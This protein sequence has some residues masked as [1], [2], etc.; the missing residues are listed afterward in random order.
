MADVSRHLTRMKRDITTILNLRKETFHGYG[1]QYYLDVDPRFGSRDDLV[2]LVNT[3]HHHGIRV[4]LDIILNHS[5]DVFAYRPQEFRCDVFDE[6]GHF[7]GKE[8]CW[9]NDGTIY[10]VEGFRVD[11]VKHMDDGASRLFTS[12]IH[13]FA[14]SIGKENFYLIAEITGGRQRAF[15]TLETVGMNAALGIND[16]PYKVEYLVKGFRN[17]EDYFNLFER[18]NGKA[19]QLNVPSAGF[20]IF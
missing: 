18:R 17:P 14:E 5:G 3:A 8:A 19:V 16:I 1:I 4:I 10:G 12:A 9:Q 15:Q 11:T 20:V 6:N 13:E 7:K 2:S